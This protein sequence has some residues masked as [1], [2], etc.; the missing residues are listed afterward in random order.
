MEEILC[1]RIVHMGGGKFTGIQKAVPEVG[2]EALCL[3]DDIESST[4]AVSVGELTA[5]RV[6]HELEMSNLRFNGWSEAD[7]EDSLKFLSISLTPVE[8]SLE[9]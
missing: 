4:L 3:F 6:R 5:E 1:R 7:I 2:L 9:K 8:V